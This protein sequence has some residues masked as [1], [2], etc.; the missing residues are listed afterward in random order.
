MENKIISIVFFSKDVFPQIFGTK[1]KKLI[2]TIK[3]IHAKL[4][5]V[6]YLCCTWRDNSN[7]LYDSVAKPVVLHS[8]GVLYDT[9]M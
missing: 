8:D 7:T 3:L 9:N 1:I 6:C 5:H 2:Q 4:F